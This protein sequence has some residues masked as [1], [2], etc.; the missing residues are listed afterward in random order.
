MK[1]AVVQG[2]GQTPVC[3]EAPDPVPGAD[4][5]VVTMTAAAINALASAQE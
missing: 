5:V 4:E 3:A 2:P 1:A